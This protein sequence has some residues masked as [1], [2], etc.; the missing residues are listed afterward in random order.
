MN[1]NIG[2]IGLVV[3]LALSVGYIIGSNGNKNNSV[4]TPK[5]SENASELENAGSDENVKS[6][7]KYSLPDGWSEE[8][9]PS[10][11]GSVYFRPNGAPEVDCGNSPE[12][13]IKISASGQNITE[14][15]QI[16][17]VAEVK[18]HI[19]KSLYINNLRSLVAETEY[20]SSSTY[21]RE[22]YVKTYYID[23]GAGIVKALFVSANGG[24]YLPG[25]DELANSISAK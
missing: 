3:L 10:A 5:S 8:T 22:T 6:I 7:V 1:K 14:C 11:T 4:E 2:I 24:S 21:G 19:C 18:K 12:L 13:S 17:D 20:L 9:C 25:F 15:S 23:S 16:Q